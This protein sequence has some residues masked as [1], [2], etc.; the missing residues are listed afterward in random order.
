MQRSSRLA[1]EFGQRRRRVFSTPR[2]RSFQ[3]I[4]RGAKRPIDHAALIDLAGGRGNQR[5]ARAG[6]HHPDDHV[7][8][9]DLVR[10]MGNKAGLAAGSEHRLMKHRHGFARRQDEGFV[11]QG[12]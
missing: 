7:Q 3:R 6:R 1:D 9:I 5:N 11:R 10:S 12:R 4:G 8:M 2:H